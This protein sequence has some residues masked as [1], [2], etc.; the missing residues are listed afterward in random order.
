MLSQGEREM[1]NK[2]EQY[3]GY[4]LRAS[5]ITQEE[6]F[7]DNGYW[8]NLPE[9]VTSAY[10]DYDSPLAADKAA[11]R[12]HKADPTIREAAYHLLMNSH[13][14]CVDMVLV[15]PYLVIPGRKHKMMLT[16]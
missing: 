10:F 5:G 3:L 7:A 12:M 15:G 11:N 13:E 9:D 6:L 16:P 8:E 14:E 4:V 2:V 1:G